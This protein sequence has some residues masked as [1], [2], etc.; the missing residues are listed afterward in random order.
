[1]LFM[2][3][4]ISLILLFTLLASLRSYSGNQHVNDSINARE[5]YIRATVLIRNGEYSQAIETLKNSLSYREKVFTKESHE[6]GI[7]QNALGVAYKNLGNLDKAIEH[8][9]L[10]EKTYKSISFENDLAIGRVYNNIG[11]IYKSKLVFNTALDYYQRALDIYSKIENISDAEIAEIYYSITHNYYLQNNYQNV[12]DLTEKYYPLAY[13]DTKMYFLSLKA[14]SLKELKRNKEAYAA[15]QSV[16]KYTTDYFSENDVNVMFEYL[17]FA[18]FL[19]SIAEFNEA[20]DVLNTVSQLLNKN[21]ISEGITYMHY[22]NAMGFYYELIKVESNDIQKFREQKALNIKKAIEHYQMAFKAVQMVPVTIENFT[23]E[24]TLSLNQSLTVLK[25]IADAYAKISD[26]Y[27]ESSHHEKESSI[28][29][30]LNYYEIISTLIQQARRSM[31]S[32]EDKILLAELEE[33]TFYK[34]I[35][36]AYKAYTMNSDQAVLNFAF[37]NAERMKASSV[38]DRLSDQFAKENSLV[39]DSLNDIERALNYRITTQNEHLYN[40]QLEPVKDEKEIAKTDSI[41]FQLKKQ[42]DELN[43]YLETNFREY[44]EMKYANTMLGVAEVQ[45]N[46]RSN[47]ALIEYVLHETDSIPD[48]YAFVITSEHSGFYKLDADSV[49]IPRLE[50]TF[51]F[52][53]NPAFLFTRNESSVRY[54]ESALYLY[55]VLLQPFEKLLQNKK[56]TIIPDGKISYLPFDAL[57]TAMPDTTGLIEFNNLPYVLHT[58]TINY[59]YSANLLYKFK[60]QNKRARYRLMALAPEYNLDTVMFDNEKLVLIP[61][62]GVQREVELIAK[63]VKTDLFRG[64]EATEQNFREQSKNYDILHL[65]MHAFIN[66]S[67]PA[68]SRLAFAQNEGI[69]PENDG[70]LNTADIYNLSLNSRLIVLSACNTGSGNLRKGEGVMSLARGFLYAG[71]PSI[72]MSMWEVEDNAGTEIMRSFYQI[73]KKGRSTDNALRQA[74]L[75]YLENANPRLAHPHYWLGYVSIGSSEPLF[76][77]Y[78]FY[79]FGLL[80]IAL[81]GISLDQII[82]FRKTGKRR[83]KK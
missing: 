83:Y 60:K 34:M 44:Y 39:P 20:R 62:P 54:C 27:Y 77:S 11:N 25:L 38:F 46:Q 52:I 82:H 1:M 64:K 29:E 51:R 32:D 56:I 72:V 15:Y 65:A 18:N 4:R 7:V 49:F 14:A 42:R 22:H 69:H 9:L 74:K 61:L 21:Q 17:S 36:T 40:L 78:D 73:L 30:A 53:S 66:D 67:L 79:F 23:I 16:L 48:V 2:K 80:I 70:W 45:K 5:T 50:E 47:K 55:R 8:F 6:Y 43:Q 58:Y 33:A 41:L 26:I 24:N 31:Y 12:L 35:G 75:K 76:R 37:T 71:C 57:L 63:E 28:Q 59:S 81:A 3:T 10:A 68:F 13:D 19:L